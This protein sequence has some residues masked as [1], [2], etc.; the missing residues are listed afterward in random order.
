[1]KKTLAVVLTMGLALAFVG[2]GK[3]TPAQTTETA[4]EAVSD[5]ATEAELVAEEVAEEVTEDVK[6]E[7][8]MTYAEYAAAEL[9]S[10]VVVET[11]V[12]NKQSWWEDKATFYTQ[13]QDGAYFIYE[14]ACS[15][16]EYN[17]LTP[18]TKIKV[19]GTKS[20]WSG[21]VEIVDATFEIEEGNFIAEAVDVTDLLGKDELIDKQNQLVS[22]TDMTVESVAFKNETPGDDIYLTLSKDGNN[23]DFCL[24]YYLNGSDEEFYN[25]VSGLEAGQTVDVEGFLYWYEGANPHITKVTV[26]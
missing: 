24:E 26:K 21:E 5:A 4:A 11:Y 6:A 15:E 23:Y 8:V 19:T 14:M 13:D 7:G 3:E 18:G 16:E 17:K 10:E 2:C 25:L 12:Q 9:D 20:E 1:M 22:F